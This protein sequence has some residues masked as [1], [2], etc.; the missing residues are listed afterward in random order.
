MWSEDIVLQDS[1]GIMLLDYRQPFGLWDLWFGAFRAGQLQGQEV[2]VTGWYRRNPA[3][4]L[5]ID[6]I[7]G[8][9]LAAPIFCYGP[10]TRTWVG[11]FLFIVGVVASAAVAVATLVG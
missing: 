6:R 8:E 2:R 3:P 10:R 1:T 9:V 11:R 4:S 5:V 7:E